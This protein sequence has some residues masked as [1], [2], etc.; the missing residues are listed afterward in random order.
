MTSSHFDRLTLDDLRRRRSAKWQVYPDDVLPLWVAEMDVL[1]APSVV[2]AVVDA[3]QRVLSESE[4]SSQRRV[5]LAHRGRSEHA[6][7]FLEVGLVD[8]LELI[9]HRSP[10]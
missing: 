4:D 8:E 9:D 2:D 7:S 1:P 6:T 3:M 10:G 5:D